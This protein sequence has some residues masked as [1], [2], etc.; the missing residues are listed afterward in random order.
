MSDDDIELLDYEQ[1]VALLPDGDS[2]HTFLDGGFA[3]IG[4]DWD[5]DKI[6]ALLRDTGRREVTGSVAQSMGHGLAAFRADGVPVFIATRA[7][8]PGQ[9]ATAAT[10]AAE[11]PRRAG[12]DD[13]LCPA[14]GGP[15]VCT[16]QARHAPPHLAHVPNGE[17]VHSWTGAA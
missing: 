5:R 7:A 16:C 9:P 8:M 14:M 3:V 13:E 15:Y 17:I 1:A 10:E 12:E 4:A 11:P 2:I 6:L